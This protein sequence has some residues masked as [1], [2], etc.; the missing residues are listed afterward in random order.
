M[1]RKA[2][3]KIVYQ[4]LIK[5]IVIDESCDEIRAIA[6]LLLNSLGVTRNDILSEK[7]FELDSQKLAEAVK[8]INLAEPIQY[9]LGEAYFLGRSFLVNQSVPI[10]RTAHFVLFSSRIS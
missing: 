3:S 7:E 1:G 5:D 8:R 6:M 9:V 10:S 2:N 4:Q